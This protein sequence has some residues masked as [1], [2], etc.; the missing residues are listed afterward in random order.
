MNPIEIDVLVIGGGAAGLNAAIQLAR[1]R[2]PVLVVDSGTPRNAPA[3][4]VHGLLG[5]DGL[6]PLEL[7]ARG[8][9]E[10][11][12]YGGVVRESE[13]VAARNT[14][15]AERPAFE[16]DLADGIL[17]RARRLLVTTGLVDVLPDIPGLAARFGRDAVHCPFCHGW[18][19][20]DQP[21]GVIGNHHMA[22]HQALLFSQWSSDVVLFL[23]R[24]PELDDTQRH[25]LGAR[26]VRL[27]SG[28]IE[29][30]VVEDDAIVGVR[31]DG[32]LVPRRALA[33][34]PRFEARAGFLAD[35]GL[36]PVPHPTG[37]GVHLETTAPMGATAVPG[38]FAAGNVADPMN[39]V[40]QAAGAGAM[41]GAGLVMDLLLE[42]VAD[43]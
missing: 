42:S 23:H 40:V 18:E 21:I 39:Q 31:I 11:R 15:T 8:R 12:R 6:P 13:V 35:L 34:A 37:L 3:A 36:V 29:E 10:V 27:I 9:E 17:V 14:G 32:E 19:V 38:I 43:A 33:V 30:I 16:V 7:L 41:A 24:A 25:Q 28:E 2:V 5:H 1:A 22:A 26:G 4:G 20:R